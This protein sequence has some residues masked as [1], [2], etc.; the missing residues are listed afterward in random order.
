MDGED[1]PDEQAGEGDNREREDADLVEGGEEDIAALPPDDDPAERPQSEEGDIPDPGDMVED[2]RAE[3]GN[4][5]GEPV[6]DPTRR[7]RQGAVFGA[8]GGG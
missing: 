6:G 7:G 4:Q 1:H 3:G 8:I 5:T 2:D